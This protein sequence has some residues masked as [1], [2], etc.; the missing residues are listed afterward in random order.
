MK[1]LQ[2]V[3]GAFAF[4]LRVFLGNSFIVLG[5]FLFCLTSKIFFLTCTVDSVAIETNPALALVVTT[6]VRAVRHLVA[7]ML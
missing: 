3:R 7:A 2:R 5:L 6:E 4:N 1:I